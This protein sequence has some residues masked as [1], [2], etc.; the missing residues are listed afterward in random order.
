MSTSVR[1]SSGGFFGLL[2]I[3]LIGLKLAGVID[4]PWW[5]VLSPVWVPIAVTFAILL[6]ALLVVKI[7]DIVGR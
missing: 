1:Y 2:G 6:M 3:L 7:A 5:V 4:W